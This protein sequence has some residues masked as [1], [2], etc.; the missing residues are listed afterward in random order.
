MTDKRGGDWSKAFYEASPEAYTTTVGRMLR[1]VKRSPTTTFARYAQIDSDSLV[2]EAGCGGGPLGL[3]LGLSGARVILVDI[4]EEPLRSAA[5]NQQAL[6]AATGKVINAEMVQ[7]DIY[8]YTPP[9]PADLVC[10]DGVIEHWVETD[11]RRELLH[12]MA[13]WLKPGGVLGAT[14]PNNVHPWTGRW[15]RMGW[16]WLK[17]DFPLREARLSPDDLKAD[18]GAAGIRDAQVDGFAVWD[19]ICKYPYRTWTRLI[20]AGLKL[21]SGYDKWFHI[22]MSKATRLKWGTYLLVMGHK[23]ERE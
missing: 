11:E 13:G 15:E 10:S 1:S 21:V 7:A 23:A 8:T 12:A 2:I 5:K 17:D 4:E 20:A 14:V 18:F 6:Q 3:A 19:T 16:P 22:P 9:E